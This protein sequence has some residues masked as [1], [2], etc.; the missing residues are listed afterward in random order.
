MARIDDD[1]AGGGNITAFLDM[2]A[3]AE[4]GPAMLAK[5]DDGYDVLVGSLP[6]RMAR[7]NDYSKH[8][9]VYV[10]KVKSTAAG[11][12][13]ILHRYWTHYQ[14]LLDLPDFS[15]ISQD[16]YAIQQLREQ[17]AYD[18]ILTGKIPQAIEAVR[19]IWAS[20]PGAGYG[21]REH[22][23]SDLMDVYGLH[24]GRVA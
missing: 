14:K 17:G 3:W 8:P 4:I 24:G 20:L 22:H 6:H 16:R 23:V 19:N 5:S 15:P 10:A 1:D 2:I 13:Q 21:Q 9:N 18:L 11:R 7:F 12:Y